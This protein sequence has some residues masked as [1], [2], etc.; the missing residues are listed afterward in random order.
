M[1]ITLETD[2]PDHPRVALVTIDRQ[3]RRN[4]IDHTSLEELDAAVAEAVGWLDHFDWASIDRSL[5]RSL[6]G[7]VVRDGGRTVGDLAGDGGGGSAERQGG[8]ADEEQFTHSV[9]FGRADHCG[10]P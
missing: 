7:V 10:R 1:A 8:A 9:S 2:L 4:A 3:E 6:H 5:E